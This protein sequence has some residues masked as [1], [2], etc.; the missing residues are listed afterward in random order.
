[1]LNEKGYKYLLSNI[2]TL[3]KLNNIERKK[4]EDKLDLELKNISELRESIEENIKEYT[5]ISCFFVIYFIVISSKDDN[6]EFEELKKGKSFNEIKKIISNDCIKFDLNPSVKEDEYLK[7][8]KNDYELLIKGLKNTQRL[9]K[10]YL[11]MAIEKFWD[12]FKE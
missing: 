2:C 12:I 5:D 4:A 6:Y 10:S 11:D 9:Q 7:K 1:M 3:E 8:Y